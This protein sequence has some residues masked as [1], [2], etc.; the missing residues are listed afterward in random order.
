MVRKR[1]LREGSGLATLDWTIVQESETEIDWAGRA[2]LSTSTSSDEGSIS[3]CVSLKETEEES[4][5]ELYLIETAQV[6]FA[7]RANNRP[8]EQNGLETVGKEL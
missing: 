6:V 4:Q 1:K 2:R 7:L 5:I 8:T 3:A